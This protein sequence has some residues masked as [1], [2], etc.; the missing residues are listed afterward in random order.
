ML[1]ALKRVLSF[2]YNDHPMRESV[3]EFH[4]LWLKYFH[5]YFFR[6]EHLGSLSPSLKTAQREH[7]IFISNHALTFEGALLNYYLY[8]HR[9]GMVHTLVFPEA[10]K[11]PL[12]REFFRST[13]C[14]PISVENGARALARHHVLLFPEGM[15]FMR[16]LGDPDHAPRFH[17]GFLHMAK[18]FLRS[19][20]RKTVHIVPIAHAG[21]ER[22]FKFWVVKNQVFMDWLIRPFFKYPFWVIP[23]LPF[24]IPSKVVFNW[25]EP[26]RLKLS[27]LRTQKNI[28]GWSERFRSTIHDLRQEAILQ[29]DRHKWSVAHTV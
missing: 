6:C 22:S 27:D 18:A 14:L 9:A 8:A 16:G 15:D 19:N 29:R 13:Q 7:V 23:K 10:F 26:I 21:V 17:T 4:A 1:G 5:D 3:Y 2:K 25:G 12:V 24:L 11:V 20:G 28:M